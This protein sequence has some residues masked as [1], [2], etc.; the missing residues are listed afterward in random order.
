MQND[1]NENSISLDNV[2]SLKAY[3]EIIYLDT[4]SFD[5]FVYLTIFNLTGMCSIF[6][7]MNK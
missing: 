3:N 1:F 7:I 6:I 5:N 2:L 4:R